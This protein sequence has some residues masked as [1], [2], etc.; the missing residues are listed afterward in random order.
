MK[1]RIS[2]LFLALALCLGLAIPAFAADEPEVTC[3]PPENSGILMES[4]TGTYTV[5][6]FNRGS[7]QDGSQYSVLYMGTES[8]DEVQT[9]LVPVGV[10][11]TVSGVESADEIVVAAWSNKED[12]G[13]LYWRLFLL[14]DGV[15]DSVMPLPEEP[16]FY[17]LDGDTEVT[18]NPTAT[19]LGF[20]VTE[21]GTVTFSSDWL[22]D[23]FEIDTL[24]R[25]TIGDNIW[26]VQL[27]GEP[28]LISAVFT[29]VPTGEWYTDPVAWA[30]QE[31]IAMGAT[32]TT[33]APSQDCSHIQILT[34]L[35]RAA[36]KPESTAAAPVALEGD[37]D[38]AIRWATEKGMIG[39]AFEPHN[40]C[41]RAEA[42]YYIWQ[43]FDKPS[44]EASSFTDVDA[45]AD[46]AGAVSWAV[47]KKVTAGTGDG[48]TFSPDEICTRGHIVTFLKRA[49]N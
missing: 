41:T 46:Y 18:G 13:E 12:G 37:Y 28:S 6:T 3:Q 32:D 48:T 14:E 22:Y 1:K 10:D 15:V 33:F 38:G 16:F 36:G 23:L 31:K 11:I 49:Y 35:W 7:S 26:L 24:L 17:L 43:A 29:D 25:I 2:A 44:A 34:F 30:V 5:N 20:S 9:T 45:N 19:Q 47:E 40:P 21:N 8:T 27:S 42:M 39:E 4:K